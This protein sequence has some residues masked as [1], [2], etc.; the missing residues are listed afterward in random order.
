MRDFFTEWTLEYLYGSWQQ[1]LHAKKSTSRV[2]QKYQL[3][4]NAW[5]IFPPF[6]ELFLMW[7]TC[8]KQT[9][10]LYIYRH[11]ALCTH[12]HLLFFPANQKIKVSCFLSE[13]SVYSANPKMASAVSGSSRCEAELWWHINKCGSSTVAINKSI[14]TP[15]LKGYLWYLT[16][17]LWDAR[18][19]KWYHINDCCLEIFEILI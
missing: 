1:W 13:R 17:G 11:A 9:C 6:Y 10:K 19:L 18:G 4:W 7:T 15:S 8:L 5:A 16:S 3:F 14:Q 2:T 12:T